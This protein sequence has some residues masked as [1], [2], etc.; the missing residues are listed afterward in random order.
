MGVQTTAGAVLGTQ[1]E[2]LRAQVDSFLSQIRA[3]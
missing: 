1:A 3:A 2:K